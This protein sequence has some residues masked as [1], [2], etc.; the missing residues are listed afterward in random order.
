[1]RTVSFAAIAVIASA[2]MAEAAAFEP[3][4]SQVCIETRDRGLVADPK[5]VLA[6][7]IQVQAG[8]P[9]IELRPDGAPVT[10]EMQV[11]ALTDPE[12]FCSAN[13]CSSAVAGKLGSAYVVLHAFLNWAAH[14]TGRFHLAGPVSVED[15]LRVNG[16]TRLVCAAPR[17]QQQHAAAGATAK[18][19]AQVRH[20]FGIRK[21]VEDFRYAQ[22]DAGFK[23]LD[24]ASLSFQEDYEADSQGYGI[25]GVVGYT[26]GPAPVGRSFVQMT[27]FLSY[28]QD[29][30]NNPGTANDQGVQDLGVGLVGD[31]LFPIGRMY[32]D[33]QIYPKYVHSYRSGAETLI[34]T[35]VYSPEPA[36]AF[37]GHATYLIPEILSAQFTPQLKA[38]YGTVFDAGDDLTLL[39][40]GDYFRWGPE[41]R[42][43][44]VRRRLARGLRVPRVLR[45]LRRVQ[46]EDLVARKVRG[47]ARL[48]DRVEGAL[49]APAQ[50]CERPGH[51]HVG[52]P[53]ASHSRR[54]PEILGTGP[55]TKPCRKA[56]GR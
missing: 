34:S 46:R 20:Y 37:F 25:D 3:E 7:L 30:V 9:A 56:R 52:R 26:F 24:R 4:S 28:K 22:D 49:G 54:R 43:R 12:G 18:P 33:L 13:G 11:A 1:M 38:A 29:Y 6:R 10:Y 51:R 31:L 42:A 21:K 36:W 14:E 16:P 35:A 23:K 39:E 50:I 2:T 41:H 53:G 17:P 45:I 19:A 5:R 40:K 8:I 48:H 55:R 27:P 47:L 15:F 44:D 32:Q